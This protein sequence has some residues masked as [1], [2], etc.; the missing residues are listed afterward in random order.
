MQVVFRESGANGVY[1]ASTF[2]YRSEAGAL[3][4]KYN[5]VEGEGGGDI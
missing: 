3:I 4:A 1:I 2:E 5:L